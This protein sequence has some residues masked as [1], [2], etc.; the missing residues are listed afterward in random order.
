MTVVRKQHVQR[1][2]AICHRTLLMGERAV[3]FTPSGGDDDWRDVCA[4]CTTTADDHGWVTVSYTH[5]TLPTTE[6]V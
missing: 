6:R 3:R 4:L 1:T 5:L 2:C